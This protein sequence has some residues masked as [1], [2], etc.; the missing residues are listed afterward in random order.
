MWRDQI[1]VCLAE[2]VHLPPNLGGRHD[3]TSNGRKGRGGTSGLHVADD[4]DANDET[5]VGPFFPS[6][7]AIILPAYSRVMSAQLDH[8]WAVASQSY[9]KP[10]TRVC[11]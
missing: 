9:R 3:L 2:T 7:S 4:H 8:T 5:G 6:G 10:G 11:V 1:W